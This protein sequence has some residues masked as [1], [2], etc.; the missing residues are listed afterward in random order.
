MRTDIVPL[1]SAVLRDAQETANTRKEGKGML[2]LLHT[3]EGV[4]DY[5]HEECARK[6][7]ICSRI[8]SV[9]RAYGYSE[10]QTPVFEYF[11]I[12]NA[13]RGSIASRNMYKLF[14][15]D[16][17]TLVL[18]PDFTPAIA[19]C[20]AKYFGGQKLPV[21]LSYLGNTYVNTIGNRGQ[22]KES[23]QAGAEL[24]GEDS[25]QA[26]A[27]MVAM[28]TDALRAV[29]LEYFQ[30]EIG[31]VRYFNAL[32][33]EAGITDELKKEIRSCIESKNHFA[34][35]ELL[36]EHGIRGGLYQV[37]TRLPQMFGDPE[38]ILAEARTLTDNPTALQAVDRLEELYRCLDVYGVSR[39]ITFDLGMLGT[40]DYYTGII[41]KGY[42]YGTGDHIATGGRY[43]NLLEQ[44]GK[45][46]ASIGFGINLETL[47]QALASQH[48]EVDGLPEGTLILY[49]RDRFPE[50]V[51]RA[52]ALRAEGGSVSLLENNDRDLRDL[53]EYI[54]ENA[55]TR[56]LKLAVGSD[57][58]EVLEGSS[59]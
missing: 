39:Y 27:E 57:D 40:Q 48:V 54:H 44:F 34:L 36:T 18:R 10:I 17:E 58:A 56:I 28:A 50:A 24:M 43:D 32:L 45:K 42:T 21:R 13:E 2:Q 11:D 1:S 38:E 46:A 5:Y 25:V 33:A 30:I 31:D 53:Q 19:R 41:F 12:F 26:D 29:G 3:P 20:A 4:R 22:M 14:D 35:E 6:L 9:F 51:A 15:R 59:L 23:T 16:G 52:R 8:R 47:M 37:L 7:T 55:I 49:D